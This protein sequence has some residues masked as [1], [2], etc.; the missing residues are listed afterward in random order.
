MVR[1]P[2]ERARL[3]VLLEEMRSGFRTALEGHSLLVARLGRIEQRI[4][5]FERRM[6]QQ[7]EAVGR[8]FSA[9]DQRFEQMDQRFGRLELAM[10]QLDHR[11]IVHEQLHQN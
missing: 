3:E 4:D 6:D 5:G 8:R 9:I 2:S 7:F 1:Q 11:L 10:G